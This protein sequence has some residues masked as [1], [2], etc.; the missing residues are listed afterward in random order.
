MIVIR[1]RYPAHLAFSH[2]TRAGLIALPSSDTCC[3]D[4]YLL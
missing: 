2:K 4:I 3:P 1:S